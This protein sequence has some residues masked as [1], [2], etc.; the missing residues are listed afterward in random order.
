MPV[1]SAVHS[2]RAWAPV[3]AGQSVSAVSQ[4]SRLSLVLRSPGV[5]AKRQLNDPPKKPTSR[6]M[7]ADGGAGGFAIRSD[8][9]H[10]F[11]PHLHF[12]PVRL[13]PYAS[14]LKGAR[15]EGEPHLPTRCCPPP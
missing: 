11:T 5:R 12:S 2:G 1:Q 3:C 14:P 10:L 13:R 8:R 6:G 7:E 4:R 15:H 9:D